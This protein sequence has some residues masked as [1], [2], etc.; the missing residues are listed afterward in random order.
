MEGIARPVL[1]PDDAPLTVRHGEL[2][3]AIVARAFL[4][5]AVVER[6]RDVE[7]PSHCSTN[8]PRQTRRCATSNPPSFPSPALALDASKTF[9]VGSERSPSGGTHPS[10]EAFISASRN[11]RYASS[12]L[13]LESHDRY[14]GFAVAKCDAQ[15]ANHR[16]VRWMPMDWNMARSSSAPCR[17]D[18]AAARTARRGAHWSS[19]YVGTPLMSV[20]VRGNFSMLQHLHLGSG[21]STWCARIESFPRCAFQNLSIP[22]HTLVN[23]TDSLNSSPSSPPDRPRPPPSRASDGNPQPSSGGPPP[24]APPAPSR[25]APSPW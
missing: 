17:S 25:G 14:P 1:V 6:R 2:E 8:R 3:R 4:G 9:S 10:P 13:R 12:T 18:M 23:H 15:S 11:W 19:K 7:N 24:G 5:V 20:P 22:T 21:R 16:A